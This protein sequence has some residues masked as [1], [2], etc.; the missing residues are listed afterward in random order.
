[1]PENPSP[2]VAAG[3]EPVAAGRPGG[4]ETVAAKPAAGAGNGKA[5]KPP[6][7]K[8]PPAQPRLSDLAAKGLMCWLGEHSAA[9]RDNLPLNIGVID[10]VYALL[11]RQGMRDAWSKRTVHKA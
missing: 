11:D 6:P 8:A 2:A 3:Q 5:G 7:A 1:M 4:Q 10:E 9:W